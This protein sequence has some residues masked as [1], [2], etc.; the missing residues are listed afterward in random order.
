MR[1]FLKLLVGLAIV[2]VLS[3][4]FLKKSHVVE[5]A[6]LSSGEI[7]EFV[8]EQG[9][10]RLPDTHSITMPFNGRIDPIELVEGAP[11]KAG[12]VIAQVKKLDMELAVADARAAVERAKA[13]IVENDDVSVESTSLMQALKMVESMAS[14]VQAAE[15]R[16]TTGEA[17]LDFANKQFRRM[18]ELMVGRSASEEQMNQA[19][20]AQVEANIEYQQNVL[21]AAA[22]RSMQAA[23]AL[24]P[25][26]VQQYISR[27]SLTGNVK[28]QEL[29]QAEARLKQQVRD[30][31]RAEMKSPIDG[32]LLERHESSERQ[33]TGGTLLAVIGDLNAL[34]VEADILSQDVVSVQVGQQVE[35]YGP[36]IGRASVTGKVR[37]VFPAGFTKVSSLGVEQ[38]RVKVVIAFAAD[39]VARLREQQGLGVGYRVRVKIF[40]AQKG[41]ALLVPRSAMFRSP[42]GAWQVFA[43]RDNVAKLQTIQVGLMNDAFAEVTDGLAKGE[44]VV[45]SPETTLVDG[46]NLSPVYTSR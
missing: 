46:T 44:G 45:L 14:T 26:I 10:T 12:Q 40:T 21:V 33:L 6:K 27:K 23:T 29:A 18:K 7:R 5:A 1:T 32:V 8:D 28:K 13:A 25:Q 17:K 31:E 2:A 4:P 24:A 3:I 16:V 19:E 35:I 34:E 22:M 11:V 43:I 39:D 41:D 37:R 9:Q 15:K 38:Q 30:Q 42:T 36:A 20:V